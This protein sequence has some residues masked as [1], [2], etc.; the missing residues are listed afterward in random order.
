[1]AI[2]FSS[3][4]LLFFMIRCLI[5][6][7]LCFPEISLPYYF[8]FSE[9]INFTYIFLPAFLFG[10]FYYFVSFSTF[11]F[12]FNTVFCGRFFLK[13]F[14]KLPFFVGLLFCILH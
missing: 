1:M 4:I 3:V 9:G 10:F 13:F 2:A 5:G 6:G 7:G 14:S 8:R 12:I 11:L